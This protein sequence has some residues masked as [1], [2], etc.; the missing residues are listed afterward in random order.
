MA[1]SLSVRG[2]LRL[3]DQFVV[4]GDIV[5]GSIRDDDLLTSRIASITVGSISVSAVEWI[6]G[7]PTG[8]HVALLL[9]ATSDE[10]RQW[11]ETRKLRGKIL[12]FDAPRHEEHDLLKKQFV[13]EGDLRALTRLAGRSI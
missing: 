2:T 7:T 5:E 1:G 12:A 4:Y 9:S 6:D 13:G 8:S 3:R 11:L 10:D